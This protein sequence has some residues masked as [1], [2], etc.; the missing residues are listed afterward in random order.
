MQ[1]LI[2]S[3]L[4][5]PIFDAKHLNFSC[6]SQTSTLKSDSEGVSVFFQIEKLIPM[7]SPD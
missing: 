7:S 5:I 4:T 1:D 6:L 2:N 3:Q